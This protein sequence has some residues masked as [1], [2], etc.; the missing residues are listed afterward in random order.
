MASCSLLTGSVA[1]TAQRPLGLGLG[2]GWDEKR[3]GQ[4]L[5]VALRHGWGFTL[6]VTTMKLFLSYNIQNPTLRG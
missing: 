3:V 1:T 4:G 5:T 2:L 6:L